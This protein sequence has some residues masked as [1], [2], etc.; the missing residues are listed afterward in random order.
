VH[1]EHIHKIIF[2]VSNM[3]RHFKM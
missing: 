2:I 3:L 1:K